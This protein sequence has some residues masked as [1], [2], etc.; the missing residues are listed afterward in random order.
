[1]HRHTPKAL[2]WLI[3]S[4]PNC[5]YNTSHLL[6]SSDNVAL[7]LLHEKVELRFPKLASGGEELETTVEVVLRDFQGYI[8]DQD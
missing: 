4:S 5:C 6:G 7:T 1:M 8:I 3:V 2:L